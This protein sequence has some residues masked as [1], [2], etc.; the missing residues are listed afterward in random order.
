MRRTKASNKS[1]ATFP[2]HTMLCLS[3]AWLRSA[4]IPEGIRH[5][6]SETFRSDAADECDDTVS[7]R[8]SAPVVPVGY[9]AAVAVQF[10]ACIGLRASVNVSSLEMPS[11][12]IEEVWFAPPS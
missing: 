6:L 12:A 5:V 2:V 11:M 4:L 7:F 8:T 1:A 9:A 10:S 3:V